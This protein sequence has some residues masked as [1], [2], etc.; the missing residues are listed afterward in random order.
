MHN[1][2]YFYELASVRIGYTKFWWLKVTKVSF[3]FTLSE[4]VRVFSA[5]MQESRLTE[6]HHLGYW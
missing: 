2:A 1:K 6:W 5:V 3:S 4:S